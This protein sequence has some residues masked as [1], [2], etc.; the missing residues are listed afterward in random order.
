MAQLSSKAF[1]EYLCILGTTLQTASQPKRRHRCEERSSQG[2]EVAV[3]MGV[4]QSTGGSDSLHSGR[5]LLR[6]SDVSKVPEDA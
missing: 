2:R 4:Q 1:I 6:E 3:I 5:G